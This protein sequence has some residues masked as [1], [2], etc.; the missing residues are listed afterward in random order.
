MRLIGN[1]V[2]LFVVITAL[3]II[4]VMLNCDLSLV[5]I[6]TGSL[7][8]CGVIRIMLCSVRKRLLISTIKQMTFK[9]F[10]HLYNPSIMKVPHKIYDH[11]QVFLSIAKW[12]DAKTENHNRFFDC[13]VALMKLPEGNSSLMDVIIAVTYLLACNKHPTMEE[14]CLLTRIFTP[15]HSQA[16][17]LYMEL[18]HNCKDLRNVITVNDTGKDWHLDDVV[19]IFILFNILMLANSQNMQLY[20]IGAGKDP[21]AATRN[22]KVLAT[23]LLGDKIDSVYF[24][25][26]P[27]AANE[28]VT[29]IQHVVKFVMDGQL[30]PTYSKDV[31]LKLQQVDIIAFC[32]ETSCINDVVHINAVVGGIQG[33]F[34]KSSSG[35]YLGF[36]ALQSHKT[37][38]ALEQWTTFS[39]EH[40]VN[41][42][43]V[44]AC[45]L[46]QQSTDLFNELLQGINVNAVDMQLSSL[47]KIDPTRYAGVR[48]IIP[49]LLKGDQLYDR[50]TPLLVQL[51]V[52]HNPHVWVMSIPEMKNQL[53]DPDNI[54]IFA[55]C[56]GETM[57]QKLF[58]LS[59][60][61]IIKTAFYL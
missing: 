26:S 27:G 20:I 57:K 22:H 25:N 52:L 32:A 44:Y 5:I 8:L 33:G 37:T 46:S 42:T 36:N 41:A 2:L 19:A 56:H 14:V 45:N 29:G 11:A 51:G 30:P 7:L 43:K 50:M 38:T 59:C 3:L 17:I 49:D 13:S 6:T 53:T 31:L 10:S 58:L 21:D 15:H 40:L 18:I 60:T 9:E 16:Y 47:L 23:G 28:S 4:N 54:N 24:I 12:V 39:V 55:A 61:V 35:N 48:D 34:D 1:T